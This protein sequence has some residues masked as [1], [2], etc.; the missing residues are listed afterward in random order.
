MQW[1]KGAKKG[2]KN[3][4]KKGAPAGGFTVALFG[5]LFCALFFPFLAELQVG[6]C[7]CW[8]S[9][10]FVLLIEKGEKNRATR[11]KKDEKRGTKKGKQP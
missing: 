6:P 10:L 5:T 3:G 2:V 7:F 1:R 8:A 9:T 4:G 11:A